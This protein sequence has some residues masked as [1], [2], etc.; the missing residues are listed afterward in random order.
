MSEFKR[1]QRLARS[2]VP[3][4]ARTGEHE[5]TISDARNMINDL[6]TDL[7][8][9]ALEYLVSRADVLDDFLSAVYQLQDKLGRKV[10]TEFASIDPALSPKAYEE[11]GIAGFSVTHKGKEI[12]FA[13]YRIGGA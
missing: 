13:E 10:V 5:Y 12:V 8:P 6:A 11:D 2:V 9:A 3:R 7:S 1:L 4:F